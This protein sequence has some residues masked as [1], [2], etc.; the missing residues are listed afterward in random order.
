MLSSDLD[1]TD[2]VVPPP[3]DPWDRRM[4]E[5]VESYALFQLYLSLGAG[6]TLDVLTEQMSTP[7]HVLHGIRLEWDWDRR[8]DAWDRAH[9]ASLAA[10]RTA[11]RDRAA[12]IA[13][14]TALKA[15]QR[16]AEGLEHLNPARTGAH[17]SAELLNAATNT[18]RWALGDPNAYRPVVSA[19]S[20]VDDPLAAI[21]SD[22]SVPITERVRALTALERRSVEEQQ[23]AAD[24]DIIAE[25][26]AAASE[27]DPEERNRRLGAA[28]SG[29]AVH[30]PGSADD[31]RQGLGADLADIMRGRE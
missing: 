27:E 10:A 17:G 2:S 23:S 5:P 12:G 13:V 26:T 8:A 25:V 24:R 9:A 6:R 20:E 28:L 22:T 3:V 14:Q 30:E 1:H 29:H 18:A 7:K 15:L 4:S 11:A 16:A 19:A 31:D 21:G